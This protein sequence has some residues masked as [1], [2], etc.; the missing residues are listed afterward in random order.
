MCSDGTPEKED[1]FVLVLFLSDCF[2]FKSWPTREKSCSFVV[3]LFLVIHTKY[4]FSG[5]ILI[6]VIVHL[7][8]CLDLFCNAH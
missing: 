1:N 8:A 4:I 6:T 5:G 2:D 7:L 3:V